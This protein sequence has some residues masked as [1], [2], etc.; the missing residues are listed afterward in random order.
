MDEKQRLRGDLRARRRQHVASLPESTRRLLFLRPPAPLAALAPEGAT[1][2]L[3]HATGAEAPGGAYA[4]WF[5]ENGRAIALP[6]FAAKDAAMDFAAWRDPFA[7]GDLEPGP[8]GIAQ[9]G[10]DAEARQ[11]DVVFVPLLGFTDRCERL[12]QG[13]GHY[14]RWLAA[15]PGAIAI[16]LAWDC[17]LCET[18]PI[19]P[20]DRP[21]HA[22]VTPT[23]FYQGNA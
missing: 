22:V 19:E 4:R 13:G 20:H 15:H 16:G 9:P 1:V 17:Q 2:G 21:L 23:R 12:G 18:L 6:R 5:L 3:Y 11:P 8:H 10:A 14:D 7:D